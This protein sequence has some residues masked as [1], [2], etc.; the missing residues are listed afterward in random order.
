MMAKSEL[1]SVDNP[2]KPLA[3][4]PAPKKEEVREEVPV[5][6]EGYMSQLIAY[7]TID[8]RL[9][10]TCHRVSFRDKL[11]Q[12]IDANATLKDGTPVTAKS[13]VLKWFLENCA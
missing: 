6:T 9:T 8:T 11:R 3:D 10:K 5:A 13:D 4:Y 2:R 1:P 7:R 12:L